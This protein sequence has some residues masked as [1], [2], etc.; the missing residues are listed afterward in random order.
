MTTPFGHFD[1][2]HTENFCSAVL[3]MA[4]EMD[5][6]VRSLVDK[7]VRNAAGL[8]PCYQGPVAFSR[9]HRMR[10]EDGKP[11]RGDLWFWYRHEGKT[12]PVVVEVKTSHR[13]ASWVIKQVNEYRHARVSRGGQK[14]KAVVLLAP[15]LLCDQVSRGDPTIGTI[16]WSELLQAWR[17]LPTLSEIAHHAKAHLEGNVETTPGLNDPLPGPVSLKDITSIFG[18]LRGFLEACIHDLGGK[19]LAQTNLSAADGSPYSNPDGWAWYGMSVPF[20]LRGNKGWLLGLYQHVG[21][22]DDDV[23]KAY[24]ESPKIEIYR[25]GAFYCHVDFDPQDLSP[26]TLASTREKVVKAWKAQQREEAG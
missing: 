17:L 1:R 22:P 6:S 13:P 21:C 5:P 8:D 20:K 10:L 11:R 24:A 25:N 16:S 12:Q 4:M 9:E 14:A 3:L 7:F 23:S 2:S 15:T 19:P 26:Q 18:C